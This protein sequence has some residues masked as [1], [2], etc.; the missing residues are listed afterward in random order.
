MKWDD[1]VEWKREQAKD[2]RTG[3]ECPKCGDYLFER[4]DIVLA[5][6]PPQRMYYCEKCGWKGTA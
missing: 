1:F 3:V 5:T 2:Q 6:Y 4:K